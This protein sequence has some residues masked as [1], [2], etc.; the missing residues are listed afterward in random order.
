M[1]REINLAELN[2]RI[3]HSGKEFNQ[4]LEQLIDAAADDGAKVVRSTGID[5]YTELVQGCP[6]DTGRAAAGF[7]IRNE[8][9]EWVPDPKEF[10]KGSDGEAKATAEI[11]KNIAKA[12]ALPPL[13]TMVISNNVEYLIPLENG[14]SVKQAPSGFI[15]IAIRN[16]KAKLAAKLEKLNRKRYG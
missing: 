7:N 4:V 16:A 10:P 9:S 6:K 1:A 3:V 15:A 5:L 14:H 11:P 2:N 13:S 12:N 8:P